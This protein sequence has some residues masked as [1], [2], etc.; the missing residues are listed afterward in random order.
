MARSHKKTGSYKVLEMYGFEFGEELVVFIEFHDQ[1]ADLVAIGF[2]QGG[3]EGLFRI[4]AVR[5]GHHG[6]SRLAKRDFFA[7]GFPG[8]EEVVAA[9][10][11]FYAVI[12]DLQGHICV[13]LALRRG[14]RVAA[15]FKQLPI[16][17]GQRFIDWRSAGFFG[18]YS[19]K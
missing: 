2:A 5:A 13:F 15:Y 7:V 8:T 19:F 9:G 4:H 10:V 6:R 11:A 18:I 12:V 14:H 1:A 3:K 16:G 17:I